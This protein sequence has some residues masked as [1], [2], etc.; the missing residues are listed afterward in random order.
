MKLPISKRLLCCAS[1]VPD[2]A[3]VADIG[4]DH[5]YL[6][7]HLLM[8]NRVPYVMACDLR[9]KPLQK[10]VENAELYGVKERMEF[11]LSDGLADVDAAKVDTVVMA[12]MGGDL[13]GWILVACGWIRDERYTLVLQPQTDGQGLRRWLGENNF[14]IEKELPVRDGGF[15][16]TVMRVKYGKPMQ[17]SPGQQFVSPWLLSS[18]SELVPEYLARLSSTLEK[19]AAGIRRGTSIDAE[20]L[21]YYEQAAKEIREMEK[22]YVN[23]KTDL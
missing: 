2:G 9:E 8:E 3:R 22:N 16:Y 14:C 13:M 6:G 19:T 23:R 17:L 21:R 15:I 18:G 11:V 20:K 12:G 7:I 4:T 10:A 5:G 1:M